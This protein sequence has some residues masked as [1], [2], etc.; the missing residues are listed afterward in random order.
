MLELTPE[1]V[2][3]AYSQGIFPMADPDT[4][5]VQWFRPDPRAIIPLDHYHASRSLRRF[6]RHS[7]FQVAFNRDFLGVM[8]GCADRP[9]TWI[10]DQ[11]V[12]VYGRLHEQG[13]AHSV[14]AWEGEELAG[15]VYGVAIGAAFMAESMFHRATNASKV[16]L[17]A[18][19]G[20]LR[21]RQFELLDVQYMTEHL[22]TLG[23]VEV[24]SREYISRLRAAILKPRAFRP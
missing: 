16:A 8:R 23:A 7:P 5:Q 2:L 1:S 12:E 14:E 10:S 6:L 13:W 20:R 19:V 15:G 17:H 22:E 9:D 4:G 21:E 3:L 18:L 11:F 24:P